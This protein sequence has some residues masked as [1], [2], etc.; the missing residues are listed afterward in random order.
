MFVFGYRN[1]S[2]GFVRAIICMLLGL[3]LIVWPDRSGQMVV[4]IIG[5][6]AVISGITSIAVTF[7]LRRTRA[8]A[9]SATS[10]FVTSV[11]GVLLIMYPEPFIKVVMF[12]IGLVL[13]VFGIHQTA[14]LFSARNYVTVSVFNYIFAVV[15]ALAGIVILFRPFK[16][17]EVLMIFIGASIL[18]YGVSSLMAAIKMRNAIKAFKEAN[19]PAPDLKVDSDG[20]SEYEDVTRK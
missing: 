19:S 1:P 17:V 12:I 4:R 5:I 3:A 6:A 2:S 18:V 13:T 16:T 15:T 8:L 7:R 10:A 14:S 20:F 9:V 11:F